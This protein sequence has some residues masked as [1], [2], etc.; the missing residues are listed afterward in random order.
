MPPSDWK[1]LK[2][3]RSILP[4]LLLSLKA[5]LS[6]GSTGI[7]EGGACFTRRKD[8]VKAAGNPGSEK[9]PE[10]HQEVA[11]WTPRLDPNR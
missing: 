10:E 1:A 9:R 11:G 8:P 6:S 5:A 7:A 2:A 3:E 4:L